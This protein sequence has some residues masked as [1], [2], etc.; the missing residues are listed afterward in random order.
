MGRGK[1]LVH[2]DILKGAE[3]GHSEAIAQLGSAPRLVSKRIV[4]VVV[5]EEICK[6]A[7][8]TIIKT[9]QT[10]KPGDG[11]IFVTPIIETIRVRTGEKDREALN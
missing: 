5:P 1:G 8:D 3:A 6:T 2:S 11:K 9:N 7:I 10:G 4:T